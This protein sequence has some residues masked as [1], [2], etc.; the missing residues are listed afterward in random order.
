[1]LTHEVWVN[2]GRH[3]SWFGAP[4]PD[5]RRATLTAAD[6]ALRQAVREELAALG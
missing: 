6:Q 5:V 1:M 2:V 4:P 3:E